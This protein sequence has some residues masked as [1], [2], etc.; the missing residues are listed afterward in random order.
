VQEKFA[1]IVG[2]LLKEEGY[3]VSKQIVDEVEIN[4]REENG[5]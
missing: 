3:C 4:R 2:S 5:I 1:S